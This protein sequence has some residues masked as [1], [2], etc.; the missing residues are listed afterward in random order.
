[1]R[2]HVVG[3]ENEASH[4]DAASQLDAYLQ[5]GGPLLPVPTPGFAPDAGEIVYA[6]VVCATARYYATDVV[7]P[8]PAGY[9][10]H[11]PTL[12]R[13]W[14]TNRRLE[15]R[16]QEQAEA[17][18]QERWRDHEQARVLLT[19]DGLRLSPA[20][21]PSEWLPFD[22]VL[23]TGLAT[24]PTPE[25]LTL[26][27]SVCAPVFLAGPAVPWLSVALRHIISPASPTQQG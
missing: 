13:R 21:A 14:L 11:H 24:G 10:E 18:A 17:E 4:T 9:F 16:R 8:Q 5:A 3:I 19:S 26:S 12:G 25:E 2:R 20:S 22:H 27:Y 7:H 15:A 6:D 23:L 1:M